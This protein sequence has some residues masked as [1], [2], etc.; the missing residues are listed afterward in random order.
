MKLTPRYGSDPIIT[1]EGEPDAIGVP[2]IRQRE[3]FVDF[4]SQFNEDQWAHPS[5]CAGWSNRDVMVHLDSTNAFWGASV[6]AAVKGKPTRYMESF[7]PV[8]SPAEWVAGFQGLSSAEV[9][10]S[11][12]ASTL[13][14]VDRI[15]SLDSSGWSA[16]GEAP[17]GHVSVQVVA[18]HALWDS[19]I[20]ERDIL[21]PLGIVP[22]HEPDEIRAALRYAASLGPAFALGNGIS[23]EASLRFTATDPAD[24]FLVD[25][26]DHVEVRSANGDS[27]LSLSGDAVALAES[28]SLRHAFDQEVPEEYSW[29]FHGLEIF[30]VAPD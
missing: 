27:D 4:L 26:C 28:L 23:E 15:R 2:L 6:S 17:V 22:A 12:S 11:F 30:G 8:E 29:M 24:D 14:L 13:A 21:L 1:M 10:D 20:H 19:W 18:H 7:D 3:R 25:V 16:L 5:R 9:F